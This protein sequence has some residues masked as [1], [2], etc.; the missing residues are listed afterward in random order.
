[1]APAAD[2]PIAPL[3]FRPDTPVDPRLADG[4]QDVLH[5]IG[6]DRGVV[7]RLRQAGVHSLAEI[8]RRSVR[9]PTDLPPEAS[10]ALAAHARLTAVSPDTEV[11]GVLLRSGITGVLELARADATRLVDLGLDSPTGAE[12]L[13]RARAFEATARAARAAVLIG[14]APVNR[15]TGL[16]VEDLE[17]APLLPDT[18]ED[19]PGLCRG[20]VTCASATSPT[21][22]LLDLIE[23][24]RDCFPQTFPDTD[25]LEAR[26]RRDF[27][28]VPTD[29][30]ALER[31]VRQIELANEVLE[32]FV[33]EARPGLSRT[34]LYSEFATPAGGYPRPRAI[35]LA[36]M[37]QVEELQTTW[38]ELAVAF[39]G[40]YPG[41]GGAAGD[42][43]QLDALL[44]RIGL[45]EAQ[46]RGALGLTVLD[47]E[48]LDEL[49]LTIDRL[50]AMPGLLREA[51]VRGLDPDAD[52]MQLP[53]YHDAVA[54]TESTIDRLAEAYLPDLRANLLH[55]A[56]H[57][58]RRARLTVVNLGRADAPPVDVYVDD[59]HLSS[60]LEIAGDVE[61]AYVA[62][63]SHTIAV[64][65]EGEQPADALATLTD[66]DVPERLSTIAALCWSHEQGLYELRSERYLPRSVPPGHARVRAILAADMPIFDVGGGVLDDMPAHDVPA[67]STLPGYLDEWLG[68]RI[69]GQ[70]RIDWEVDDVALEAGRSYLYGAVVEGV[71]GQSAVQR[72]LNV[73]TQPQPGAIPRLTTDKELGNYLHVDLSVGACAK[74]TRIAALIETLQSYVLAVQLGIEVVKPALSP[75]DFDARWLW[76]QTY[77]LWHAAQTVFLYP[78][79]FLLPGVRRAQSPQF[80]SLVDELDQDSTPDGVRAAVTRY[81][82]TVPW[83]R[84]L[85]TCAIDGRVVIFGGTPGGRVGPFLGLYDAEG[86][87]HGW[88]ALD[89]LVPDFGKQLGAAQF[90]GMAAWNGLLHILFGVWDAATNSTTLSFMAVSATDTGFSP[91]GGV[92]TVS[93]PIAH[94]F[95]NDGYLTTGVGFLP[96]G[97]ALRIYAW[98]GNDLTIYDLDPEGQLRTMVSGRAMGGP[99]GGVAGAIGESHYLVAGTPDTTYWIVELPATGTV[100]TATTYDVGTFNL[101]AGSLPIQ[102]RSVKTAIDGTTV[103]V[104]ASLTARFD[105][106]VPGGPPDPTNVNRLTTFNTATKAMGPTAQVAIKGPFFGADAVVWANGRLYAPYANVIYEL[107][108]ST[109]GSWT[110]TGPLYL[111]WFPVSWTL[112]VGQT[113]LDRP[114]EGLAPDYYTRYRA[115]QAKTFGTYRPEDPAYLYVEEYYLHVPLL[116]ASR[117]GEGRFFRLADRWLRLIYNPFAPDG[118]IVYRNLAGGANAGYGYRDTERWLRDPF[119]PFAIAPTRPGVY[120]RHAIARFAENLIEW[121]DMEFTRDTAESIAR[122]RELYELAADVLNVPA[123][124][125]DDCAVAWRRVGDALFECFTTQQGRVVGLLIAPV[126]RLEDNVF[127][128]DIG[129]IE[130]IM[131]MD[132]SFEDRLVDLRALVA[133]IQ[134]RDDGGDT[135]T[136]ADL[137]ASIEAL[138]EHE[139]TLENRYAQVL[140]SRWPAATGVPGGVGETALVAASGLRLGGAEFCV[141]ANPVLDALRRR[142]ESSL[143]KIRNCR[144]IAG[145]RRQLQTYRTPVNP[146][147]AV[148][149]AAAGEL[150]EEVVPPEPPPTF[151]FSYLM[152]RA[153]YYTGL[154]QQLE[155]LLL[156]S[157]EKGDQAQYDLLK[158]RQD[159]K[160]TQA[161]LAL[162]AL[163]IAEANDGVELARRQRERSSIQSGYFEG[164]ISDGLLGYEQ[165]A[166]DRLWV[167][168]DFTYA[169]TILGG[170][171]AI[172]G[173]VG[174]AIVGSIYGG[175]PGTAAGAI[176]G[177]IAGALSGG[178]QVFRD[179][180]AIHSIASQA[181]TLQAGFLRREQ[182]WRFQLQLSAQDAKIGDQGIELAVDR[183]D[184]TRQERDI[185]QLHSDFAVEV[186]NFLSS[187]FTNLQ[188]Y[189]WMARVV[190]RLYREHLTIATATARMA[191]RALA[192]ERQEPITLIAAYYAERDKRDLLA[193]EQLLT[194][195][196]KLDQYRLVTEKRRKELTKILSLGSLAPVEF[197]R[198]RKEGW[199]E[200]ATLMEWF[201]ADFPGHYLRLVKN[202]SVTVLA[203]VPPGDSLRLTLSNSGVSRV[204]V[205]PPFEHARVVQRM[206]ESVAITAPNN[207]TGL[208][209]VR[210]DDPILLPFEGSGVES[211]WTLE[212][213]KGANRFDYNT[214]VDVLLTVRYTALDDPDYRDKVVKKLGKTVTRVTSSGF[215]TYFPDAWYSLHNPVFLADQSQY[216]FEPG[217]PLPPYAM[218]FDIQAADFPPNEQI[219]K[220]ERFNITFQQQ[221]YARVPLELQLRPAGGTAEYAVDIDFAW[222]PADP[223]SGPPSRTTFTRRRSGPSAAWQA[224]QTSVSSLSPIGRWRVRI[225]NAGSDAAGQPVD[226]VRYPALFSTEPPVHSQRR[227]DLDWLVDA[228]LAIHYEAGLDYRYA[229][230]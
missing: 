9:L 130:A 71:N 83:G 132:A 21:A 29:C 206:P 96:A 211:I 58:P 32:R 48:K 167:A 99:L 196:S 30:E 198:L 62:A 102:G 53:A 129:A 23:F 219:G 86:T 230:R 208:F 7:D 31:P 164:L 113:L 221:R 199:M 40:A 85:G 76:L 137:L 161:N 11:N 65:A 5:A 120:L 228:M 56:L 209:E 55:A 13:A 172:G 3:T 2:D 111:S 73:A 191:Q 157:F 93:P 82:A 141:P 223:Q 227:L 146:M 210:L 145:L 89:A 24:I 34:A 182:E 220:M 155:A 44:T 200:F 95:P 54:A 142:V 222:D 6:A 18:D 19:P 75:T 204:M 184:I 79:N 116:V 176:V 1:M 192:F 107:A 138:R 77:G 28:V 10:E 139:L 162:Q 66:F 74:T 190:R 144:N 100:G 117:L 109:A 63:G 177:G 212:M 118:P 78:E 217:Q 183:L 90:L 97:S 87:W 150:D 42:R 178:G 122:A 25:A 17:L 197:Q 169:A 181:R 170:I 173:A 49:E 69:G 166:I 163:R 115:E 88:T 16:F 45:T 36:F 133:E 105:W 68:D 148:E 60:G 103:Y 101:P 226:P 64:T 125:Q 168:H 37:A 153:R 205:E 229:P 52:P 224:T 135:R 110:S 180:A 128:A 35:G 214:L 154:A 202:V 26:F 171:G 136:L 61:W 33:L 106:S 186:V 126:R 152:D 51:A 47:L 218:Q 159:L 201:D 72:A 147:L 114:G 67:G 225:K 143:D 8:R 27:A 216:G 203:L 165:E 14:R 175:P 124:A 189:E 194:D 213:P 127:L 92:V 158:A 59:T 215:R 20:C 160:S 119:N 80:R 151:R 84:H 187:K 121:A 12:L 179:I 46:I 174:G 108:R 4:L 22:Y 156:A 149:Q 98:P 188:L 185:A 38:D 50:E 104:L 41:G 70:T 39:A 207:G 57:G 112:G 195:L 43:T 123:T 193:A 131:R 91:R 94:R 15:H 140:A 134:A 81:G